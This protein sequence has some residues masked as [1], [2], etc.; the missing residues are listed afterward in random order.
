[1]FD[2]TSREFGIRSVLS[3]QELAGSSI[4]DRQKIVQYLTALHSHFNSEASKVGVLVVTCKS[5]VVFC[6]LFGC[7]LWMKLNCLIKYGGGGA[8]LK[9]SIPTLKFPKS[10]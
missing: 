3:A 4:P 10:T 9:K 1:M 8:T 7:D 2:T 5:L 6:C